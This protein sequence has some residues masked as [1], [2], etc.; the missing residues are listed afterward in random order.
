VT[1]LGAQIHVRA[2]AVIGVAVV[3]AAVSSWVLQRTWFGRSLRAIADDADG[4]AV[5]GISV[6]RK[7][8]LAFGLWAHS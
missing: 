3:V 4:A 1:I 8:A 7:R 2:F 6:E 5:V